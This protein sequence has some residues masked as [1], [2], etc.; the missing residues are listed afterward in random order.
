MEGRGKLVG[1]EGIEKKGG[2]S[3][4]KKRGRRLGGEGKKEGFTSI[5]EREE[6]S[7]SRTKWVPS[8]ISDCKVAMSL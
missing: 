5:E 1:G 6:G 7:G 8:R 4:I 3:I 2:V